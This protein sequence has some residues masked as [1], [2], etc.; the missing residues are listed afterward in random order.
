MAPFKRGHFFVCLETSWVC[1]KMQ[2]HGLNPLRQSG[3][4]YIFLTAFPLIVRKQSDKLKE[5]VQDLNLM[6]TSQNDSTS[7]V[8]GQWIRMD[9]P[10]SASN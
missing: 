9:T 1:H 2:P 4:I 7:K 3:S 5:L 10:E 8:R 6:L